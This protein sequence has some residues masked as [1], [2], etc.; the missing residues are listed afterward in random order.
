M[1][2]D[3][4]AP[5]CDNCK[6]KCNS[7]K[8]Q[9]ICRTPH[10]LIVHLKRFTHTGIKINRKVTVNS[11]LNLGDKKFAIN[12]CVLHRGTETVGH[13]FTLFNHNKEWIL[14][15]DESIYMV[16]DEYVNSVLQNYSYICI[17]RAISY[18]K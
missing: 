16:N 18:K 11:Y 3:D 4:S 13:Y 12:V 8:Q 9:S 7:S 14:F 2:I 1:L 10:Y 17:Y 15:D 5:F 6:Q